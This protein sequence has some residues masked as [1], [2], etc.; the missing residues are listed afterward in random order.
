MKKDN[1][2]L[3]T[4]PLVS[5]IVP[6]Y[7]GAKTL[8]ATVDSVLS[9]TYEKWELILVNDGSTD[10]SS[11]VC[12]ELAQKDPRIRVIDQANTGVTGA[13][14]NGLSNA[15][16]TWVTFLDADDRLTPIALKQLLSLPEDSD[17]VFGGMRQFNRK[18]KIVL[19]LGELFVSIPPELVYRYLFRFQL[20]QTIWGKLI[21]MEIARQIQ[22]PD[23][24]I[25][26]GEDV[27]TLYSMLPICKKVS[28]TSVS[29][30]Y[31][32]ENEGST[33]QTLSQVAVQSMW[34]YLQRLKQF[35]DT[36]PESLQELANRYLLQEY[37]AYL[38]YGGKWDADFAL[39][40][41]HV[42]ELPLKVRLLLRAHFV[43]PFCGKVVRIG[44]RLLSKLK[45]QTR[46]MV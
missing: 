16:G 11:E 45:N 38:R 4:N 40:C 30:Y 3:S 44:L 12:H 27:L 26:I 46:K 31:Y 18:G 21:R 43:S 14:A 32:L 42:H 24:D 2:I 20:P 28:S 6:V 29:V 36:L 5:V 19:E 17:L 41:S 15:K 7:N 10:N 23:R 25:R 35:I 9:Q 37:Y 34:L 13:R 39:S 33:M 8:R 1:T 22:W